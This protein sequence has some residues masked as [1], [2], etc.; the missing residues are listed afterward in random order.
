MLPQS[1]PLS[2]QLAAQYYEPTCDNLE[3]YAHRHGH[4][5][6]LPALRDRLFL[7]TGTLLITMGEKLMAI[8]LK[9]VRL[10]EELA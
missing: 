8:S 7:R 3:Q 6:T 4:A 2:T 5:S 9:H 1:I 10:S